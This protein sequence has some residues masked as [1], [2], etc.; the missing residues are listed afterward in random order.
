M[1]NVPFQ[2][3]NDHIYNVVNVLDS[4]VEKINVLKTKLTQN[5]IDYET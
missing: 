5:E 1:L 2:F 4:K 3:F